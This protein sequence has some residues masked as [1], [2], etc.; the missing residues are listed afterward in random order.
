MQHSS[1]SEREWEIYC[2]NTHNMEYLTAVI[3]AENLYTLRTSNHNLSFTVCGKTYRFTVTSLALYK[4]MKLAFD[5]STLQKNEGCH[6]LSNQ[7]AYYTICSTIW[8]WTQRYSLFLSLSHTHTL[9]L[10]LSVD[11]MRVWFFKICIAF[12]T[13]DTLTLV[14]FMQFMSLVLFLTNVK[15]I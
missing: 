6:L 10:P 1:E 13:L 14:K 3:V 9:D 7:G 15:S 11:C 8:N 4:E 12:G 2:W 5:N